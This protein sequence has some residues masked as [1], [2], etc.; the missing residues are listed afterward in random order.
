MYHYLNG[1]ISE[2][3]PVAVILVLLPLMVG[4]GL[5][6]SPGFDAGAPWLVELF[7]GRQSARTIHFISASLVVGF[8][9]LHVAMV[10][11]SG[12]WNNLRSMI[13]GRYAIAAPAEDDAR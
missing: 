12:L 1:K 10:V 8:I 7:G 11:A 13:T 2:K 3:T 5:T 4:T 9:I 6:M